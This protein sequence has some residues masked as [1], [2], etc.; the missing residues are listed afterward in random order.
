MPEIGDDI[1]QDKAHYVYIL[2]CADDTL[3]T[4]YTNNLQRRIATH[5]AG[6]GGH[7]TRAHRPVTLLASWTFPG[8]SEALRAEYQIKCLT[9]QQK[10]QLIAQA[11]GHP[12]SASAAGLPGLQ[13]KGTI[14]PIHGSG[15][16]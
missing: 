10:L 1:Q 2:K 11:S 5:N 7:Y 8:K 16:V 4:G 14:L 15:E 3:Y 6:K 13:G 9:R 12:Q